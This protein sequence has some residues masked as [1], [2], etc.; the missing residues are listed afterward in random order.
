MSD[1]SEEGSV[2]GLGWIGGKTRLLNVEANTPS[3]MEFS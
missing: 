3:W 1:F 2:N